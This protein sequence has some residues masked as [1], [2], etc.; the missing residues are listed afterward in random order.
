[1]VVTLLSNKT[2]M[3]GCQEVF[4]FNA[5][6]TRTSAIRCV[7]LHWIAAEALMSCGDGN[8]TDSNCAATIVDQIENGDYVASSSHSTVDD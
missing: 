6:R 8:V 7:L 5:E 3:L 2:H 4:K 1:M